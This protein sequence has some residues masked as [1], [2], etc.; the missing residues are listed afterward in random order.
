MGSR[1]PPAM[2]PG[3]WYSAIAQPG[4]D[5]KTQLHALHTSQPDGHLG[6]QA[7]CTAQPLSFGRRVMPPRAFGGAWHTEESFLQ[8]A[9]T[10]ALICLTGAK[11][12]ALLPFAFGSACCTVSPSS[13]TL[14][15]CTEVEWWCNWCS[16]SLKD[17]KPIAHKQ[18]PRAYLLCPHIQGPLHRGDALCRTSC[19]V[20][21]GLTVALQAREDS[22]VQRQPSWA[23]WQSHHTA[24][25][26]H[27]ASH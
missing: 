4:H 9:S 16:S 5:R 3:V 26:G 15:G 12:R 21:G 11:L 8:L 10:E 19:V 23:R 14:C 25:V 2:Q 27:R 22:P 1:V 24:S 6:L 18:H 13:P 7:V 20:C 17:Q